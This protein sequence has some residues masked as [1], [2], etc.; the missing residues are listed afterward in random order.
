[1]SKQRES[2][3]F[4][5]SLIYIF[6]ISAHFCALYINTPTAQLEWLEALK[7]FGPL[8]TLGIASLFGYNNKLCIIKYGLFFLY[9]HII[10]AACVALLYDRTQLLGDDGRLNFQLIGRG[11]G[12]TAWAL[13]V[14]LV[15]T[16]FLLDRHR[17][18]IKPRNLKIITLLA[19]SLIVLTQTRSAML[20]L[21]IYFMHINRFRIKFR[22]VILIIS[23]AFLVL[24]AGVSGGIPVFSQIINRSLSPDKI[25]TGRE[26]IWA[27]QMVTFFS[28]NI[29]TILFG[30]DLSP[31]IHQIVEISYE[32]ADPH[33]A[34]LDIIQYYGIFG[35][36]YICLWY[37]NQIKH[38]S[39]DASAILVAFLLMSLLVSTSRYSLIFY[40]NI[41]LL[42]IPTVYTR[43][44]SIDI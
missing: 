1:M 35:F 8:F 38:R 4:L 14:L 42:L 18:S 28:S 24:A 17:I 41:I 30:S 15:A 27:A 43:E 29:S 23:A 36:G 19:T 13:C 31:K 16:N 22:L 21:G 32:T 10:F 26:Y 3:R 2:I 33:N 37:R 39:Y 25:L 40:A 5:Y 44:R 34:Y 7:L 9:L 11:P 20:F 6:L 12:E